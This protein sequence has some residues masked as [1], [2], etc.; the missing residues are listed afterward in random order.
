MLD[1]IESRHEGCMI[2]DWG[3]QDISKRG[4]GILIVCCCTL[5]KDGLEFGS[6]FG[7]FY[8]VIIIL[9]VLD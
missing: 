2:K 5:T 8:R 1:S 6:I 3:K 4:S 7:L 9:C